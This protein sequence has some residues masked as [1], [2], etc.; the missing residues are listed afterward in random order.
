M[1]GEVHRQHRPHLHPH[2][3]Q[4][5]RCRAVARVAVRHRGLDRQDGGHAASVCR[6]ARVRLR[7][8]SPRGRDSPWRHPRVLACLP[9]PRTTMRARCIA[10][11]AAARP[12]PRAGDRPAPDPP[13][14]VGPTTRSIRA[15]PAPHP[16]RAGRGPLALAAQ[17]PAGPAP[18]LLLPLGGRLRRTVASSRSASSPA[19]C[20][21]R[22]ASRWCCS[23]WR[24][25]R[26]SSS[27]R[28]S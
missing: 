13:T 8:N 9:A 1:V 6:P 22:A 16:D 28:T 27:G 26:A 5:K 18:A 10:S 24:S 4:R 12:Q 11:T 25:G 3:H 23:A 7:E 20:P 17:D 19:R 15:P 2:P 14:P 21:A